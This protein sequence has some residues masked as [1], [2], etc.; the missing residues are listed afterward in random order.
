MADMGSIG[1]WHYVKVLFFKQ[2]WLAEE[3]GS[4]TH[5]GRCTPLTRFE[6]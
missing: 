2:R 4:R 1:K 5:Q 6:V 3:R